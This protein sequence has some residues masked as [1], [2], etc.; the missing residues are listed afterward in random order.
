MVTNEINSKLKSNILFQDND[1]AVSRHID[2]GEDGD[3]EIDLLFRFGNV[4]VV[5]EVKSIVSTDSPISLYRTRGVISKA[6]IQAK[7][8][9]EF[10]SENI[11]QA[12]SSLNWSFCHEYS[13]T[14]I[15]IIVTSN[16][17][18]VGYTEQDVPVCDVRILSKYFSSNIIP[19]ISI[20]DENHLAWFEIYTDFD[21][22]Q[23]NFNK[24]ISNPP[25]LCLSRD[26]FEHLTCYIPFIDE[27]SPKIAYT[28]LVKK[29]TV[30][31]DIVRRDFVFPLRC[32]PNL[33][34]FITDYDVVL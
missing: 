25:Q 32:V 17:I 22:A 16:A 13:Y 21:G 10:I 2:L 34:Q 7:R 15:P 19:L 18:S 9:A 5:G 12:F 20:D 28:R 27:S 8:K 23:E 31:S 3:E 33:D 26:G 29:Q 30:V 6:S 4:V 14:V 1:P 24:Y 11:E